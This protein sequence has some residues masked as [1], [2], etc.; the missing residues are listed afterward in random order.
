MEPSPSFVGVLDAK[1]IPE[2][3][4]SSHELAAMVTPFQILGHPALLEPQE[5]I[6]GSVFVRIW[7]VNNIG[8]ALTD[9]VSHVLACQSETLLVELGETPG[10][11]VE[12]FV[13]QGEKSVVVLGHATN[14]LVGLGLGGSRLEDVSD[15]ILAIQ[16]QQEGRPYLHCGDNHLSLYSK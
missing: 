2:T 7:A 1:L 16:E 13:R 4:V 3:F 6:F 8:L 5:E 10:N 9:R 12:H 14:R 11:H 15:F